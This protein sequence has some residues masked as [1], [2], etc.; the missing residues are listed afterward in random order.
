MT[1]L[2]SVAAA[3]HRVQPM[4]CRECVRSNRRRV[5]SRCLCLVLSSFKSTLYEWFC[6]CQK[7]VRRSSPPSAL[8]FFILPF[9]LFRLQP[10]VKNRP[11]Y[12]PTVVFTCKLSLCMSAK[13]LLWM[14]SIYLEW[15]Q[16]ANPVAGHCRWWLWDESV[17]LPH[18]LSLSLS[19]KPTILPRLHSLTPHP[20]LTTNF[21]LTQTNPLTSA[22]Q[23]FLWSARG[24]LANNQRF[25]SG[26]H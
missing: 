1:V 11:P 7:S 15:L 2:C 16:I 24:N 21:C 6:L 4:C 14:H 22:F 23:I 5:M 25:G 19:T 3:G 10:R 26:C 20:W 9:S 8:T 13:C 17:S 18:S 12:C